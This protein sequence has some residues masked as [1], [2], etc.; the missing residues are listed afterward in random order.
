MNSS[1]MIDTSSLPL[2]LHL[3]FLKLNHLI[4]DG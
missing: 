3:L 2:D 4:S 1:K